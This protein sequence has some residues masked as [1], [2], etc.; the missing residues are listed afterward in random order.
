MPN[1]NNDKL[2][3]INEIKHLISVDGSSTVINQSYLEF[4][5]IDELEDI[6]NELEHKKD[7]K[8]EFAKEYVNELYEKLSI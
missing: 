8:K 4:F 2:N 3:L 1:I 6:K 7:N 5:E